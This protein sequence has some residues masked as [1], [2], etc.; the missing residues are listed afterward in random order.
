MG[1][2][3]TPWAI[4]RVFLK[5]GLAS[6]GGG[7][8][9]IALMQRELVERRGWITADQ[10]AL[11]FGLSK[12]TPGINILA[13]TF[14]IGRLLAGWRGLFC[15]AAGLLIPS[16]AI[17]AALSAAYV[18]VRDLPLAVAAMRGVIPATAGMTL[19]IAVAIWPRG[20]APRRA[21]TTA[22]EVAIAMGAFL[23]LFVGHLQV[24]LVLALGGAAGAVAWGRGPRRA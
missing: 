19:A 12:I 23:L 24:P 9:T 4:F 21:G 8:T 11:T 10:F 14:L 22:V 13:H 20:R 1:T 3:A 18:A 6:F 7:S 5:I 2:A 17:T 15:G 16:A